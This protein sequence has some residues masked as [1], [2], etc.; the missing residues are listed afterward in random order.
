MGTDKYQEP[1]VSRYTRK[2][3]QYLFSDDFKF[4]TWRKCWTALAETEMELGLRVIKPP[5][6]EELVAAQKTIDYE[7]AKAKEK[8]IRHDVMA[9]DYEYGTHCP[10]E[11]GIIHLGA[12]SQFVCC[13]TDLIQ[14]RE[15][16]KII[17]TGLI[18]TI[19]NLY[20]FANENTQFLISSGVRTFLVVR[21]FK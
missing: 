12:T 20:K 16:L 7:V 13:N 3:M 9:H 17:K 11:K 6:I 15:A 5:M 21:S 4:Q 14:I 2:Q 18:N 19:N 8:T 1:L 10:K